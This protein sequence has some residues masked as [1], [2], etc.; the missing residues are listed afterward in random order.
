MKPSSVSPIGLLSV[1]LL[2]CSGCSRVAVEWTPGPEE[3][4]LVAKGPKDAVLLVLAGPPNGPHTMPGNP[5]IWTTVGPDKPWAPG[6]LEVTR[7]PFDS[8]GTARAKIPAGPLGNEPVLVQAVALS[9]TEAGRALAVS[10]CVVVFRKDGAVV[11]RPHL[12][13]VARSPVWW[14]LGGA[15]ALVVLGVLAR[16][17]RLPWR[18]VSVVAL[19]L[20]LLAAAWLVWLRARA[21][22][23]AT[24]GPWPDPSLPLISRRLP[25][26][27]VKD[28]VDRVTRPGF[29]A[30][31]DGVREN[32]PPG[33][34][35]SILPAATEGPT[36]HDAWQAAWM[37]WPVR[38]VVLDPKTDP[39]A[40]RGLYLTLDD[41]P[42][43]PGARVLFKNGAA[44]LWRVQE[45]DPK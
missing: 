37:L 28:P 2:V 12:L 38:A 23:D 34:T 33:E 25:L 43:R 40:S 42:K 1:A 36:W 24:P 19:P 29:R 30:F 4:E 45:G 26:P 20:V 8:T 11:V 10:D 13:H 31:L 18:R 32:A 15:L 27:P 7:V 14:T 39:W 22:A 6:G 44:C 5:K 16:R 17:V 41:G 21:P 3:V 35:I 9:A